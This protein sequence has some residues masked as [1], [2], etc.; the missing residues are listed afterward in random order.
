MRL[1]G[2]SSKDSPDDI[3]PGD[4]VKILGLQSEAGSK[5]NGLDGRVVS[6]D[7][8]KGRFVVST[9]TRQDAVSLKPDNVKLVMKAQDRPELDEGLLF[10]IKK[11]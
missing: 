2:Y 11:Q 8:E 10:G 4:A 6:F 5:L 3:A 9:K 1:L 7:A